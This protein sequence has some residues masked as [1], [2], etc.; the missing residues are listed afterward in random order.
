VKSRNKSGEISS[1]E[2]GFFSFFFK[3]FQ[4]CDVVEVAIVHKMIEPD[5][6]TN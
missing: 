3:K 2:K 4:F 5:L 6:A 1:W